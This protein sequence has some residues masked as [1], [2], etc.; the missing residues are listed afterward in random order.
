[1]VVMTPARFTRQDYER[2]PEGFPAQLVGGFLVKDPSPVLPHQILVSRLHLALAREAGEDRV[3]VAPFDLVLDDENIYQPDVMVFEHPIEFRPE[4]REVERPILVVEVLSPTTAS[5]D[6]GVKSRRYLEWG[7]RE[8]WLVD[9]DDRTV[10]V[11][12]PQRSVKCGVGAVAESAA[13]EGLRVD[14]ARLFRI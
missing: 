12:T 8:V 3:L 6:L 13:V 11:R 2:L 7:V 10:E 4:A 5:C 1:M 9:P 14:L